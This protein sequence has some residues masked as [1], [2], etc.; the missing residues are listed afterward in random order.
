[1]KGSK[2]IPCTTCALNMISLT[3]IVET[4]DDSLIKVTNSLPNAG[5]IFLIACGITTDCIVCL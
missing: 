4:I 3:P 5:K 1:M 2:D